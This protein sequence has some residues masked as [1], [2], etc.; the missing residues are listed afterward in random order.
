MARGEKTIRLDEP[1]DLPS[2]EPSDLPG[3][4]VGPPPGGE[5]SDL[6]SEPSDLPSTP[7]GPPSDVMNPPEM[8]DLPRQN[9]LRGGPVRDKREGYQKGNAWKSPKGF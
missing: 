4:P 7:V 3:V 2:Q 9:F 1:S 5:A 6:P 8:A